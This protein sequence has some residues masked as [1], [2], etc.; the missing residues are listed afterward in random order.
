MSLTV[1]SIAYPLAPIAAGGAE[2]ALH[3]LDKGL[4]RAGH[5]SIVI[6]CLKNVFDSW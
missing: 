3:Q 2:Q 1:L 6:G 5:R 4:V